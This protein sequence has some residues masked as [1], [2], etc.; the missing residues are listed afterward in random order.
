MLSRDVATAETVR[1]LNVA[2]KCGCGC[3]RGDVLCGGCCSVPGWTVPDSLKSVVAENA[4]L[5]EH[6]GIE[7]PA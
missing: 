1:C 7:G 5:R 6:F 3:H 2:S 4:V